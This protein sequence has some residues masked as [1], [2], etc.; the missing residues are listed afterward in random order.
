MFPDPAEQ[1]KAV[2]FFALS[3]ALGNGTTDSLLLRQQKP[4]KRHLS[5]VRLF[6]SHV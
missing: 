2:S 4:A 1:A 3:G 5:L 6:A